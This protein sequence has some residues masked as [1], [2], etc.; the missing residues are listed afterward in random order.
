MAGDETE[1]PSE[2]WQGS[3]DVWADERERRERALHDL[4]ARR[5]AEDAAA[6]SRATNTPASP[7]ARPATLRPSRRARRRVGLRSRAALIAVVLVVLVA[8]VG[9]GAA[10]YL[11]RQA[12]SAAHHAPRV[13]TLAARLTILPDHDGIAVCGAPT[14]GPRSAV[15]WSPNGQTIAV[16]GYAGKC[17]ENDPISYAYQPG[18]VALYSAATGAL[19]GRVNP[20]PA[21]TAALRLT[22]PQLQSYPDVKASPRGDTSHQVISYDDVLWSP[23]GTRLALLFEVDYFFGVQPQGNGSVQFNT[24]PWY[25]VATMTPNGAAPEVVAGPPPVFSADAP[26]SLP[27]EYDLG[28]RRFLPPPPAQVNAYGIQQPQPIALAYSW[29]ADGTLA[30]Q[31]PLAPH[32]VPKAPRLG[33]VGNPTHDASFTIWQ[34]GRIGPDSQLGPGVYQYSW[35]FPAWSPDGRYL[36]PS[37]GGMGF[38]ELLVP[39]KYGLTPSQLASDL[40]PIEAYLPIR[41]AGLQ[42]M[43]Q[44]DITG[45]VAWSPD[46]RRL[47]VIPELYGSNNQGAQSDLGA[48]LAHMRVYDCASGDELAQL[49]VPLA[50]GEQTFQSTIGWSLD[51]KQVMVFAQ[52]GSA[53][54]VAPPTTTITLWRVP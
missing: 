46:G 25:S 29:N 5:A 50:A 38:G 2:E 22:P 3:Q 11:R 36:M 35:Q 45:S 20:D 44:H 17:P 34:P 19:I 47:A 53:A 14:S 32:S 52:S 33:P 26:S 4:A 31:Q 15:A 9:A 12:A 28:Q 24:A 39:R 51:D 7:P 6:A 42:S 8:A 18:V 43:L 1:K 27:W 54:V 13:R 30:I 10:V 16:M 49:S 40:N 23:D 37:A 21:I 48:D 41:D